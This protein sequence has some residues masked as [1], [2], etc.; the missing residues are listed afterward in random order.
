VADGSYFGDIVGSVTDRLRS[1]CGDIAGPDYLLS[2]D[3]IAAQYDLSGGI[4]RAAAACARSIAAIYARQVDS[5]AEGVSSRASQRH[6]HYMRLA[7]MYDALAIR[8]GETAPTGGDAATLPGD[9]APALV[10]ECGGSRWPD[11]FPRAWP[12]GHRW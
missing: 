2:D 5:G 1:M 10:G 11:D 4:N 6:D 7:A 9:G 3:Q 8:E 12:M